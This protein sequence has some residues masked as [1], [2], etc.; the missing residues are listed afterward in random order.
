MRD[1]NKRA[2]ANTAANAASK[3]ALL[4]LT[5]ATAL[6]DLASYGITVNA[7]CP[8]PVRSNRF[9]YAETSRA[10]E[11]RRPLDAVR[12]QGWHEQARTIPL[13]RTAEP[14]QVAHLIVFLASDKASHITG[15]GDNINGGMFFH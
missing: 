8:G 10:D 5:Q 15:R 7:V 4:G 14:E 11:Q 3:L 13:G 1:M 2:M 6:E 12:E 9:H